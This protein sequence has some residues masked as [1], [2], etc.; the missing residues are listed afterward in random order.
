MHTSHKSKQ[1]DAELRR[2]RTVEMYDR[3]EERN[4]DKDVITI[5]GEPYLIID[6]QPYRILDSGVTEFDNRDKPLVSVGAHLSRELIIL[7][8]ISKYLQSIYAKLKFGVENLNEED[9]DIQSI[10][11]FTINFV[12]D[13]L[14]PDFGKLKQGVEELCDD[15]NNYMISGDGKPLQYKCKPVSLLDTVIRERVGVCRHQEL[16]AAYF[17]HSLMLDGL[18]P[19]GHV[20]SH[21]DTVMSGGAHIWTIYKPIQP[22]FKNNEY[23]FYLVDS[24]GNKHAY[25]LT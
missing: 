16:L 10:L 23:E 22:V 3:M 2:R 1:P 7:D 18:W 15:P 20:F 11:D 6:E 13:C 25:N 4:W 17:I 8:P 5:K 14:R 19:P 12:R 24:L 9:Q 21:R